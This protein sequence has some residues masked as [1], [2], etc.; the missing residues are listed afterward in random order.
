VVV[1][2]VAVAVVRNRTHA[3][4]CVNMLQLVC[5]SVLVVAIVDFSRMMWQ[6]GNTGSTNRNWIVALLQ[7]DRC[8]I[9]V[10]FWFLT[11]LRSKN[12]AL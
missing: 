1:V 5:V 4:T 12:T 9:C 11:N 3:G 7:F 8:S 6:V 2:A 10:R